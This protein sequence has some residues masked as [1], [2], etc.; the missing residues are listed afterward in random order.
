MSSPLRTLVEQIRATIIEENI[1]PADRV[2]VQW[3][4]NLAQKVTQAT[5]KLGLAVLIGLPSIRL[6]EQGDVHDFTMSIDVSS[7]PTLDQENNGYDVAYRIFFRFH[8]FRA[9]IPGSPM[10]PQFRL[11]ARDLDPVNASRTTLNLTSQ[12]KR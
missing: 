10:F 3:E 11:R 1:C 5:K 6:D 12:L 8:G 7:N 9:S 2:F 4:E